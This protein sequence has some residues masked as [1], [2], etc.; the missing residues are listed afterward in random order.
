MIVPVDGKT[1]IPL[2]DDSFH[3]VMC[4]EGKSSIEVEGSEE[5]TLVIKAGESMFIPATNSTL[6]IK[7]KSTVVITRI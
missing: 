4:I 5:V 1:S 2:A 6:N 3:A 7:G